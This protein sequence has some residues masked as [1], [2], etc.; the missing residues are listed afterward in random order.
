MP[1]VTKA[2][3][4]LSEE[5]IEIKLKQAQSLWRI[6]RWLIIRHAVVDP[7]PARDIARRLGVAEQTVH[8]LIAAYNRYGP[9]AVETPGKGQ[10]QRAYLTRAE[11][12]AFLAP[13]VQQARE[14]RLT[15][16]APIHAALEAHLGHLVHATT[17]YRLLHRHGY[18]KLVPRPRHVAADPAVQAAFKNT[19]PPAS[20]R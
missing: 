3:P 7:Q 20:P 14:G 5:E 1:R 8:N 13:V 9:T 2:A 17:V 12:Q 11:E 6:R 15:S 18:R 4:H 16:I 10:R 19:S